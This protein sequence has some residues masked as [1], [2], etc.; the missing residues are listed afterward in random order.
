MCAVI[1]MVCCN[2][3]G[4][5]K[6]GVVVLRW[7][8]PVLVAVVDAVSDNCTQR[9]AIAVEN[10]RMERVLWPGEREGKLGTG[11]WGCVLLFLRSSSRAGPWLG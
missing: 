5:L 8:K 2:I 4:V 7:L 9:L 3:E 10:L 6:R 1:W 11:V